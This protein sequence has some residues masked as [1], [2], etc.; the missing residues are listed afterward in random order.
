MDMSMVMSMD[1][2]VMMPNDVVGEIFQNIRPDMLHKMANESKHARYIVNN[3]MCRSAYIEKWLDM[4]MRN[5]KYWYYISESNIEYELDNYW[6]FIL[7]INK[8]TY[9]LLL[10]HI[11]KINKHSLSFNCIY[12]MT[13][14]SPFAGV[15]SLAI[16]NCYFV[17]DVSKLANVHALTVSGCINIKDVSALGSLYYLDASYCSKISDVSAL[18]GLHKLNLRGCGSIKGIDKLGG[19][20]TLCLAGCK[21]IDEYVK[22][23]VDVYE[24]DISNTDVTDINMLGKLHSLNADGCKEL[25]GINMEILGDIEDFSCEYMSK[26]DIGYLEMEEEHQQCRWYQEH[27]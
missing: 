15:H 27:Y 11:K 6:Y 8:N 16:Y 9:Q 10:K 2:M 24:L 19:V 20:H 3:H 14:V 25:Y 17:V 5:K 26:L 1:K 4:N 13:D 23:F 18:G 7:H 22:Y 21:G 12:E